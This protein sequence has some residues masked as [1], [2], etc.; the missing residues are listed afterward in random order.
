VIISFGDKT[1][2]DIFHGVDTKIARRIAAASWTRI[3]AKLDLLN[4]SSTLEDL[5]VPPSNHLEKL[6]GNWAGFYSIRVNNQYRVIFRFNGGAA[7]DVRC[8]DY[9]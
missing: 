5:R 3:Q 7:S 6:R 8:T 1:T 9:H 4:A 2:E